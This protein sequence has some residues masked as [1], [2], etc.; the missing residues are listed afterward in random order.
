MLGRILAPQKR[1]MDYLDWWA[2]DVLDDLE[3][4]ADEIENGLLR[5]CVEQLGPLVERGVR[6]RE[7]LLAAGADPALVALL[8]DGA[9]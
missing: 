9:S 1:S 8:L 6:S 5:E 7:E 4:L 3:D 2:D